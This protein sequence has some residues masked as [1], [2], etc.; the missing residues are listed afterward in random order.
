MVARLTT[1]EFIQKAKEI[2][3]E[4]HSY[5][6]TK[7]TSNKKKLIVTCK[8]H[9]DFT[10]IPSYYLRN[11]GGCPNCVTEDKIAQF[12]NKANEIH[13]KQYTYESIKNINSTTKVTIKCPIHGDFKQMY[14]M[15][16]RGQGCPVC[17]GETSGIRRRSSTD[18]FIQRS[19]IVHNSKYT[20]ENC[21]YQTQRIKVNITCL[22]HGDFAQF[23]PLHLK[24]HGCPKCLSRGFS[25][26][27]IKWIEEKARSLRMKNVQHAMNVGEFVIPGIGKVDGYH[28]NTKTVFEFHGDAY[29]G[30]PKR[31]KPTTKCN[32]YSSKTAKDLYKETIKRDKAIVKAGYRL[33][34]IWES[35]YKGKIFKTLT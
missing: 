13:N 9:G 27:A 4:A 11:Y 34:I 17:K 5:K 2:Y 15:H 8:N 19:N 14:W 3:G 18:D 16:L 24:G 31:Y 35:E 25:K 1:K 10:T 32:P 29:H 12:K 23:P 21:E 28:A 20:Y 7:Y 6:K 33:I 22:T 26:I 30:N